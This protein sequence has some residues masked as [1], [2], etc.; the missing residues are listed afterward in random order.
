[1]SANMIAA[2]AESPTTSEPTSPG[3]AGMSNQDREFQPCD[4][5]S[6]MLSGASVWP[7]RLLHAVC[8]PQLLTCTTDPGLDGANR[9]RKSF[10]YLTV[11]HALNRESDEHK[12]PLLRLDLSQQHLEEEPLDE[13]ILGG[14][15][16]GD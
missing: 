3:M 11:G 10:G 5:R 8:L 4:A 15:Q 9:Q 2:P 16:L 7:F 12:P 13:I 1:M 14:C 6:S